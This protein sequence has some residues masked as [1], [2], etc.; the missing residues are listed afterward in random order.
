MR[1]FLTAMFIIAMGGKQLY[2]QQVKSEI[3]SPATTS[4]IFTDDVIKQF[5]L[6]HPIRRVYNYQDQSGAYYLVLCESIDGVTKDDTLH[7][8]INAV[9]LKKDGNGLVKTWELKD[10]INSNNANSGQETSIW[11]WTKFCEVKD[12]D[13]DGNVDPL[14][15]YGSSADDGYD[16]GRIKFILYYKGQKVAIRHQNS[17]MDE[18]RNIQID[19][20]FYTL[21]QA[22]QQ[23]IKQLMKM[24]SEKDFALYPN[25]YEKAMAQKKL[26]ID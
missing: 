8:K 4:T 20:A 11:F 1:T 14:I 2:A 7:Q 16:D 25:E 26:L 13:G 22:I 3:L 21:P 9:N 17:T 5:N 23:H 6:Q 19:A 15:I 12:L 18:G 24:L 10:F